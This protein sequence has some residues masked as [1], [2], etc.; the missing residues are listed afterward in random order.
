MRSPNKS[1]VKYI[2]IIQVSSQQFLSCS[3]V[4]NPEHQPV[5]EGDLKDWWRCWGQSP[6]NPQPEDAMGDRLPPVKN[7]SP[8]HSIVLLKLLSL[9]CLGVYQRRFIVLKDTVSGGGIPGLGR[10]AG[11]NGNNGG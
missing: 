9:H 3:G 4:L 2:I 8:T 11:T 1:G 5:A 6:F 7:V 10:A